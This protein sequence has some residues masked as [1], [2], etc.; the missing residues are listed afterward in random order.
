MYWAQ[1]GLTGSLVSDKVRDW[2]Y[3]DRVSRAG[4][5]ASSELEGPATE[6]EAGRAL[7]LVTEY[8]RYPSSLFR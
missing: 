8:G 4:N 2:L 3:Y 5:T 6:G 7:I 1:K